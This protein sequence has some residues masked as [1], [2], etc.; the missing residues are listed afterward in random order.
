MAFCPRTLVFILAQAKL[1]AI[2][3]RPRVSERDLPEGI[4]GIV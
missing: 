3:N 4:E 2:E 1:N